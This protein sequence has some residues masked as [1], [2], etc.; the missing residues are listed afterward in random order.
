M[1]LAVTAMAYC[2]A[3][4]QVKCRVVPKTTTT[5]VKQQ[6][7][8]C[9]LVPK[10]VCTISPDRRSV[11][12]Y[13][14]VDGENFET[15]YGNETVYY[16]PTGPQPGRKAKFETET[17]IIKPNRDMNFCTRAQG[18]KETVCYYTGFGICRDANGYYSYCRTPELAGGKTATKKTK[19][20]KVSTG[21]SVVLK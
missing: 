9:N 1:A 11:T 8:T 2:S 10:N 18:S 12:C 19:T 15:R 17:V 4:A 13:K 6:V 5:T 20:Y 7:N 14:T 21:N 16:G 3:E